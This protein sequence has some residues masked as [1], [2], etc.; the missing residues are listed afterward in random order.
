MA[1][2]NTYTGVVHEPIRAPPRGDASDAF[3]AMGIKETLTNHPVTSVDWSINLSN[4]KDIYAQIF[5][6]VRT[7]IEWMVRATGKC[8]SAGIAHGFAFISVGPGVHFSLFRRFKLATTFTCYKNRCTAGS[9][10]H[11]Y[12]FVLWW[13][14]NAASYIFFF[15]G[16]LPWVFL[17]QLNFEKWRK[18]ICAKMSPSRGMNGYYREET[19]ISGPVTWHPV[20]FILLSYLIEG[21]DTWRQY[22]QL[23]RCAC[24]KG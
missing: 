9:W 14:G 8:Q 12:F 15:S 5:W 17:C 11:F 7:T 16:L 3:K 23:S 4:L 20:I 1:N 2:A 10:F 21:Y 19:G 13:Q 6:G 22:F 18:P 24:W